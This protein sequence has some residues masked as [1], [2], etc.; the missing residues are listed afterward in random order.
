MTFPMMGGDSCLRDG[1]SSMMTNELVNMSKLSDIKHLK[2]M[3]MDD[4]MRENLNK[5]FD[6]SKKMAEGFAKKRE[7]DKKRLLDMKEEF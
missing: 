5:A 6:N 1:G 7:E 3:T 4:K 2:R